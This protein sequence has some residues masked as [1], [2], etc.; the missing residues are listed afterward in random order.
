MKS[1][2]EHLK[3]TKSFGEE[4]SKYYKPTMRSSAIF[5]LILINNKI[6][7][8]YT[9]M[10]YWLKKR[11][12]NLV[13]VILTIRNEI[14]EKILV[15]SI[16]IKSTK[17]YVFKSSELLKDLKDFKGSIEIEIY[18]A[19]DMV[20]P[21]PAITFALKG[22]QGITFVH[23]CGRIYNDIDDLNQNEKFQVAETGFDVFIRRFIP[24]T[25]NSKLDKR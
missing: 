1:Y 9:F 11:N 20:F 14:G 23:T 24:A 6:D 22:V 15:K 12:I 17:S 2:S 18:S 5:P 8:I 16:E 4:M 21:Y 3:S 19:V 7:S 13:T 10:G 25:S